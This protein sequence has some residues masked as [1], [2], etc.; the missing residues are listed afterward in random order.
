M[1]TVQDIIGEFRS[2]LATVPGSRPGGKPFLSVPANGTFEPKVGADQ[3][4]VI[5]DTQS[6]TQWFGRAGT[7]Q[8]EASLLVE[9]DHAPFGDERARE[10][11]V[12]RDIERVRDIFESRTWATDGIQAVFFVGANTVRATSGWRTT[13]VTFRVVYTGTVTTS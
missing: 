1:A 5:G 10:G 13:Q 11:F 12:Q 3:F 2:V 9:L 8:D 7:K 4:H 6:S